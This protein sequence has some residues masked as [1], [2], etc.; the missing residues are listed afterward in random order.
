MGFF[1]FAESRGQLRQ[2]LTV[3]Q[4]ATKKSDPRL[5]TSWLGLMTVLNIVAIGTRSVG[6]NGI[7]VRLE[8]SALGTRLV[9]SG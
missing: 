5:R 3:V 7:S 1:E 8:S 4:A 2:R 6:K 9:T